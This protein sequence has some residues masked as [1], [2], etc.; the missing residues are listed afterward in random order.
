MENH[1][2]GCTVCT[3]NLLC[4]IEAACKK[5]AL[6]ASEGYSATWGAI[7]ATIKALNCAVREGLELLLKDADN[8]TRNLLRVRDH[9]STNQAEMAIVKALLSALGSPDLG[10]RS[11]HFGIFQSQKNQILVASNPQG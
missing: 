6:L 9:E 11:I 3:E 1:K 8:L 2:L 7:E 10:N 4:E 5:H